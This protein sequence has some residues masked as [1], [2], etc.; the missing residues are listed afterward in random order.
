MTQANPITSRRSFLAAASAGLGALSLSAQAK[1]AKRPNIVLFISDDHDKFYTSC[2]GA[3]FL[4]TPNMDRLAEE[5]MVFD[6]A[7]TPTA[8]CAP[9]RAALYTGLHPHRNGAHP[10]HSHIREGV[11]TLPHYLSELGYRVALS[12]KRHIKPIDSF[13]FEFLTD[14]PDGFVEQA[15]AFLADPGDSPFCLVVSSKEPHT[16]HES[17]TYGPGDIEVSPNMID[18]PE[19][20]QRIADYCTDVNILDNEIGAVLDALDRDGLS[21]NTLFLYVGDHGQPLPYGKWTCYESGLCVPF[22]ARWPGHVP[23]GTRTDAM[24]SFVDLLPTFMELAGG[25]A[26]KE[27]DG[28]S[29]LPT[30]NG[31]SR[32]H[33]ECLFGT[34]TTE[35]M[36]NGGTYPIRSVRDDRYK[37][38]VNVTPENTFTNNVT[39]G[40]ERFT[41]LWDSWQRVAETDAW[42]KHRV[43]WYQRRP[44]EEFY[45]LDA[46]PYELTNIADRLEHAARIKR[47]RSE[48]FAWMEQ[49]DDPRLRDAKALFG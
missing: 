13:P 41:D 18:T 5:G 20:R 38:I 11:R 2:Y 32:T 42:A 14:G 45:D 4:N 7:Y 22:I 47:L 49:Q 31:R 1:Q 35:G 10:N 24:V 25:Q 23:A 34:H 6:R 28:R 8:M 19:I 40:G 46:D 36:R 26:P 30:L 3:T 39:E 29:I 16:P 43:E 17:G 48:L 27:L 33:R 21:E 15:A 9:S 12:G 44:K 37:Y